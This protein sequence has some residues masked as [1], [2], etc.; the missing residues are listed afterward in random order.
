[1]PWVSRG[2]PRR[3][4]APWTADSWAQSPWA[5]LVVEVVGYETAPEPTG[6]AAP[7]LAW[8]ATY[9]GTRSP[10]EAGWDARY[11]GARYWGARYWGTDSW[12]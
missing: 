1:M 11:W 4:S 3:C 2:S 8:D 9:W 12:Q 5:P 7:L 10:Q 6:A